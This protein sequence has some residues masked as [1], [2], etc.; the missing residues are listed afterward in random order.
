M[1]DPFVHLHV[2]SGYS[3]QYGASHPRAL[4]ERAVDLEMD[5]LALTDRDG[6]YGAVKFAKECLSAG[7]RPVLGVD[8]A[9]RPTLKGLEV[10]GPVRPGAGRTPV[11]GGAFRDARLPRATFLA[12]GGRAGWAAICRLVS[13]VHL[14][15]ERGAPVLDLEQLVEHLAEP[16]GTGDLVV[17]LGPSSELGLAATRRRD[18]LAHAALAPWREL[19]PASNLVVELVSHRLPAAPAGGGGGWGPGTS[20]HAARMAGVARQAGLGVVLS[21]AVRYV[22]RRDA[23]TV[24]VLDAARRLVPLD[25]RHVDRGNAEGFLKSGKQMQEVAEEICRMA[26]LGSDPVGEA[27]H[28]L[29]RTRLVADRCALDP[30]ADLGLGEVH[31][32]EFDLTRRGPSEASASAD[33]LLRARCEG[34]IGHRYGSAPRQRIWKRL[35]DELEVIGRLGYAS[36]FLT[37]GDVTDLIREMGV[38]SA[39][40]GSGA[41]SLV[42]YLLGVSGVDPIRHGLLMERFLSPLRQAL[43]DID[44]DVES[45]RRL[46]IYEA[47]LDTYGGERC[48]CVSMMDTYRVRHAVRDVGAA[49][50]MPPGEIDAIAKAFPHIRARDARSAM[51]DLPELRA[52]GLSEPRLDLMFDLVERLDG[53]PRHIAV[54]PCGVLLSDATL[55]DRTPVE[56]SY[57]GF[58]MS[59]FDKDD[60]EDLGLLKLDVL[61]IRM[62]SAMAHAV[63]E[64]RRVDETEIDLDD[65]EQ[66]SFDDETTF[67]MISSAKTLGVFQIESPGQRELVGKSGIE[68][69]ED[70]ITDI[71]LFRPGPVKSDMITPYLNAKQGWKSPSYLHEDLRPI[72]QQTQGVVV[73]HEQ[74]IE[75][76]ARFTRISYAEA[77]EKRRALGDAESMARTRLWFFPRALGHGYPVHVVE[78]IWKVL[79]AFASFGFCKA[80]A[81]AFALPT[82]QSAWLKAHWPAHFLSGV[83]THDPGMYPKRLILD[84]ARRL[85]I[86]ILGLDVNASQ[87]AYVVEKVGDDGYGIRLA[88]DEVKGIS[89]AE[90]ARIVAARPYHSLTDFWQRAAVSRPTVERLVL[91]GGFDSVYAIGQG[92]SSAGVRRRGVITRRDLLLQVAE[93]DRHSRAVERAGRGRGLSGRRPAGSAPNAARL[94]A[95]DAAARNSSDAR[96][97]DAAPALE[98]HPFAD[99]GVWAKAAAQSRA[100]AE[101]REV[102]SVQLTLDL[103]DQPGEGQVSGLPELT[104]EEQLRAELEILGLDATRHVMDS[105]AT[106][107]DGLGV[108]R[109]RDLLSQRSRSEVL[110]AGVK[111][112]TQTPPIRSGRRVVFLTLDDATGPVDATFFEDAQGPYA[113]TVFHSWLL[114]VRGELRRTGRRGVSLRATGCWELP[115]LFALWRSSPT[116]AEGLAAVRAT[117]AVQPEGFESPGERRV[118]VHSSGFKVSPYADIKPAGVSTRDGHHL[119]D[120]KLWHRSPGSPG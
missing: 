83:L 1:P 42:N 66:I 32:P 46:E 110:V 106:F 57:A 75:I 43:P 9:Y 116:A 63:T 107:L 93:L 98:R 14:A 53:L 39:A 104:D 17:L 44:I 118:L 41:G 86:V 61:G 3:L 96:E 13:G 29:A 111:V 24:D 20:A 21:N 55:L 97:R 56:A 62:Q 81:A 8:L 90:V 71:S 48:V 37:V 95:A 35:D 113:A 4:V 33:A 45:A 59:Q 72:L 18:D 84:D 92:R 58:P 60:V 23:P 22:D 52:G 76:I 120:R 109:S 87:Q 11:R 94:R 79:E 69:F 12:A 65:E 105:Y 89:G 6:T 25:L 10:G 30:R 68:S 74:V 85:G 64:I 47:I 27:R 108:V 101:P 15:G 100:T 115:E 91:A 80:H 28:L 102:D 117:M 77:D 88:L 2:A 103:G 73:F 50:G 78:G 19:V 67:A 54:H 119:V 31:F 112:A 7:I 49:L 70:I 51:R 5:T 26:G 16:L 114:L 82:Y 34:A 40:R 36:Y 99:Q 38:R